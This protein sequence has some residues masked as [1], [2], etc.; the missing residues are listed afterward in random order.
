MPVL[1]K[2]AISDFRNIE[3]QELRFSPNVNCI[4]GN[5]GEGKTNLLDAVYYLSM[6]KSAFS[7]TDRY[8]FRY[9]TDHF[10]IGGTYSMENGLKSRF[11]ILVGKDEKKL[12]RDEKSYDRISS[13]IGV[14]PVVMVSPSDISLVSEGGDERRKFVNGVLSQMDQEYLSDVQQ[15]SR[16]LLQRNKILKDPGADQTLLEVLDSRMSV[17]ASGIYKS[18]KEFSENLL[19]LVSGIYSELSASREEI[20]ITYESDL[21][22]AGLEEIFISRREKDK[23]LGYTSA[24]PQRDD[25]SF[26]INGYPLRRCGS[27]GQQKSFLVAL[28]FAQYE[29]MKQRYGFPPILLLDDVFD[30]LD[31][32]RMAGLLSIVSSDKFG[33]I[34]LTDCN[35]DRLMVIVD[36]LTEQRSYFKAE[37]GVFTLI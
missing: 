34:F 9:G 20:G 35:R 19:P 8:N 4:W 25:F 28:K 27:Q 16:L 37:N 5:N 23:A 36:G 13:H 21:S 6:T 32:D 10:S 2:I 24:G 33:Q 26:T 22:N 17:Y 18:R 29:L 7:V 15:Y 30:K 3:F 14:L 11:S 12:K 31:E 1:E